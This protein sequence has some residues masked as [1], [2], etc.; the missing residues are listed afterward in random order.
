[1]KCIAIE[2]FGAPDVLE[3]SEKELPQPG[4]Q[5]IRVKVAAAGLNFV[6]TYQRKGLY[7]ISLPTVLGLEG[8]GVVDEVG[9]GVTEP[10]VGDRVAFT[11]VPGSYAEYVVLKAEQA[12]GVPENIELDTAAAVMLQGMTAHYLSHSTFPLEPVHTALVLAAAGGVGQ[13]LVQMAKRRGARVL[14]AASTDEKERIARSLGAD[15]VIRYT[16]TDLAEETKRLTAGE[17]VDVVYDSVGKATFHKSLSALKPRGFLVLYG[18]A[19][20][21]VEEIDPQILNSG[22]SLYL[23]RPSLGHYTATREELLQRAGDVFQWIESG[24]LSVTIDTVFPL[25][26]ATTAH[27]YIEARKTKGKVLLKP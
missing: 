3:F 12:V 9:E 23:T 24:E 1:M 22:G 4:P 21:P 15:E 5:E 26:D 27:E 7:K 17:G 10:V 8:A 13:L 25:S 20:G 18:Q 6:D 19:G 16:E 14:A 2:K 11:G